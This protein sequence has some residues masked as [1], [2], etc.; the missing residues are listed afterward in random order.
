MLG[1][2]ALLLAHSP[3]SLLSRVNLQN[4]AK[5]GLQLT[6]LYELAVFAPVLLPGLY[7]TNL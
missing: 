7:T 5:T 4:D 6:Q 3:S 1:R 2:A